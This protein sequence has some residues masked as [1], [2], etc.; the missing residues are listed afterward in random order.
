MQKLSSFIRENIEAILNE[1]ESFA[2]ALPVGSAMDVVALRDHA[3]QMLEEIVEDLE[4]PQSAAE[5]ILKSEGKA[6]AAEDDLT[7]AQE[8]GAGRAGSGFT[9]SQMVAEFRALRA[10]VLRLWAQHTDEVGPTNLDE[11]TRFNEAIDQAIAESIGKYTEDI[12]RAR[13]RFLAVLGH[14]LVNPL[15]AILTSS[16]FMLE[17]GDLV[18][19]NQTLIGRIASSADRMNRLV[20][21]LLDFT[22]TRFG[23]GIPVVRVETDARKLVNDVVSEVAASHP[24]RVIQ[25]ELTGDLHGLWDRERLAQMLSNLIGNAVQHGVPDQPVRVTARGDAGDVCISVHNEGQLAQRIDLAQ[26]FRPMKPSRR[27][28]ATDR[29]HL[30]LGLYI[31]D[32]IVKAHAGSIEVTSERDRGTTFTVRLPKRAV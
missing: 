32:K 21:D 9:V 12:E 16:R 23:D 20:A 31:V 8:H 17:S 18:E 24:D 13:E 26:L 10:S 19:P 6:D 15:G 27:D 5:Q 7:A 30:G 1:W 28:H 3:Q 22:R 2:R 4:T 29:R 14:D 25:T 11:L